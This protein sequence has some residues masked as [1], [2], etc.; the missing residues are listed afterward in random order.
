MTHLF[1][2]DSVLLLI[3]SVRAKKLGK[4]WVHLYYGDE[5]LRRRSIANE[6]IFVAKIAV[7]ARP[8]CTGD[9]LQSLEVSVFRLFKRNTAKVLDCK[10]V[11]LISLFLSD[12]IPT[13]KNR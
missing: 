5:R 9:Q 10:V 12:Y 6:K 2:R 1:F 13:E 3:S 8:A 4:E 7:I 11:N